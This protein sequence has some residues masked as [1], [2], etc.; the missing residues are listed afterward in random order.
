MRLHKYLIIAL[1]LTTASIASSAQ[2]EPVRVDTNLVTVN[3]TVSG[4]RGAYVKGL[5]RENFEI[6]D[7][8]A[9]Q[10]IE[11]FSAEESA[12]SFGIVYDMHPATDE[13]TAAVLA[14]LKQFTKELKEKDSYFVT[15]FNE[16]GS[17]TTEFVPTAEQVRTFLSDGTAKGPTSLYDAIFA[18]SEKCRETKNTKKVLLVLTDGADHA[19]HH[20]EKEL[21]LHL[22]SVNLP[23]YAVT[24]NNADRRQYGYVDLYR[25]AGRQTIG[26]DEASELDRGVIAELSKTSGGQAFERSIQSRVYLASVFRKVLAEVQNQ[27]V[28]GFYPEN[29]DGKWHKLKISVKDGTKNRPKVSSRKGY[30]SPGKSVR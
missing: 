9:K 30:Q 15:V 6:L 19:S 20:S 21:R 14:A 26:T 12:V 2:D 17:L 4:K 16:K 10:Q 24:F 5:K 1:I 11:E 22:R 13:R 23:I 18:A 28:I 29:T 27:Y 3:V 7:N 8:R 25:N